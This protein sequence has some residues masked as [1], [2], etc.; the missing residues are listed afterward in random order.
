MP[1]RRTLIIDDLDDSKNSGLVQYQRR[2]KVLSLIYLDNMIDK[3]STLHLSMH[4]R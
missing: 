3:M 4:V 2:L 1:M